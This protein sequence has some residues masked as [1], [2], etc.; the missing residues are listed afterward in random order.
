MALLSR[1][2]NQQ[3]CIDAIF[4]F[5]QAQD[6][7][8]KPWQKFIDFPAAYDYMIDSL[9]SDQDSAV[10][11]VGGFVVMYSVGRSWHG[12]E[13]LD[14][15]VIVR[16]ADGG[17]LSDVLDFLNERATY[18]GAQL[19]GLGTA[20]HPDDSAYAG[21]L[22]RGGGHVGAHCVYMEVRH[23]CST[24]NSKAGA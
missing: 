3:D 24:E 19:I 4:A 8:A 7:Q 5:V 2:A 1:P 15:E 23:G 21:R 14:E 18:E 11:R 9:A 10:W 13:F 6:V 22:L 16:V 17:H 20:Y 12:I